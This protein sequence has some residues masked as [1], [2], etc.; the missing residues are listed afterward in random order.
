MTG[1]RAGSGPAR[2]HLHALDTERQK[3]GAAS[4]LPSLSNPIRPRRSNAKGRAYRGKIINL[5]RISS[6]RD[7]SE[8]DARVHL[9]VGR[10]ICNAKVAPDWVNA[11]R[12]LGLARFE[13]ATIHPA[14]IAR[15]NAARELRPTCPAP[16]APR[17]VFGGCLQPP[18]CAIL[19]YPLKRSANKW[20][21]RRMDPVA[22]RCEPIDARP[23]PSDAVQQTYIC[24]IWS[25]DSATLETGFCKVR[26]LTRPMGRGIVGL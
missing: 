17:L 15:P 18:Q 10:T 19:V 24:T 25:V 23:G 13:S 3:R 6:Y 7:E 11:N 20:V 1:H 4:L 26:S 8:Q 16:N 9:R 2:V 12:G 22:H 21:N 14:A 5:N